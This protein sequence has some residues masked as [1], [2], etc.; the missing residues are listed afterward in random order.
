V[1]A[2][3]FFGNTRNSAQRERSSSSLLATQRAQPN[4]TC[5]VAT[6]SLSID[7]KNLG[8]LV[9]I[10][11]GADIIVETDDDN[12]PLAE[13][14]RPRQ[15]LQSARIAHNTAWTN[16][17]SYFSQTRIWPRG[18]ALDQIL[19]PLPGLSDLKNVTCPVQQGL[20]DDNPDVDAIYRLTQPLPIQFDRGDN[21]GLQAYSICPFNSQNTTWF[22]EA[23]PLLYLPSYC[24]FRMTDIWRSFVA[25][26][27]MWSCDW[28]LLFHNSTVR[29]ERNDHS[30]MADFE[31]EISG[32]LNNHKIVDV[33]TNL[34][35]KSGSANVSDNLYMCYESLVSHGFID[36]Q[37]LP[38]LSAWIQDLNS[39]LK[40]T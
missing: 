27:V 5:L 8:Y 37:E 3:Q 4:L 30:L 24:S 40:Q 13:F 29:Q 22:A 35:L 11:V 39:V 17:Y 2:T 33:L 25:Q 23:F 26:R 32:Y 15:K 19:D 16:V 20:A 9:A 31:D 14:W 1:T 7:R 10:K 6:S 34:Q 12:I 28:T 38:L 18:F 36:K 21:V